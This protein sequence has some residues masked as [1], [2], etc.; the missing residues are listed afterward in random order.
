MERPQ[1]FPKALAVLAG[2]SGILFIIPP[3][4]GFR[5]LGQYATAPAFGS[6]GVVAYKK[7]S[8]AFV[9][10]PTLVIGVIY[11]CYRMGSMDGRYDSDLVC[12]F[13]LC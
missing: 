12:R 1:D 10:V 2:I 6:L 13:P 9:I 5:Y 8:F 4:I 11:A 3:A 7:S